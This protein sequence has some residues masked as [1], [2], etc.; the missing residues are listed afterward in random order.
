[1]SQHS[2]KTPVIGTVSGVQL[3]ENVNAIADAL[4]TNS[5]GA[6]EPATTYPNMW[7]ADI[8]AGIL[9]R[10]NAADTGWISVMSLT[11]AITT[12]A[13]TLLI[14]ANSTAART[15]LGVGLSPCVR[16]LKGNVNAATPLTKFD[17]SSDFAVLMDAN[18]GTIVD[19]NSG[20]LTVD[21][22]LA[23]SIA[24]GRDQAAAFPANSWLQIYR[25]I[26]A[27]GTGR[28]LIASLSAI[29]PTLPAGYTNW[30]YATTI[31]WNASSNIVPATVRGCEVT[32]DVDTAGVTR[33]LNNGVATAMTA[34]AC[35]AF[36]PANALRALLS[37]TL[38]VSH[39][40]ISGFTAN[41]GMAGSVSAG[42]TVARA[43]VAAANQSA[44]DVNWASYPLGASQQIDYALNLVPS[45]SGGLSIDVLGYI[46]P[47][48]DC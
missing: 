20:G 46:I 12:F 45:T 29:A 19:T 1:M 41:V 28:A 34:V 18:W 7:W 39:N 22:G 14:S 33:V 4:A 48:G 36:V 27:D 26:K 11:L 44:S 37:F 25:I 31:K 6:A 32:F 17:L 5:S 8:T 35:S 16:G 47:N 43:L 38:T 3:S 24:G 2:L 40:A 10:R 13:E 30:A 42:Q 9:K 21:L 23:G 15:A